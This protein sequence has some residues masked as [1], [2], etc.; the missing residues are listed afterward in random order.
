MVILV[1]KKRMN[2]SQKIL[3]VVVYK[4]IHITSKLAMRLFR[5]RLTNV[6]VMDIQQLKDNEHTHTQL[7][8]YCNCFGVDYIS[9]NNIYLVHTNL[10]T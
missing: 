3:K 2:G 4:L 9:T 10:P 6:E 1:A 7:E 8:S 5:S